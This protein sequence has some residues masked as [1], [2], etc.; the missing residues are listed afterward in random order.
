MIDPDRS[1]DLIDEPWIPVLAGDGTVNEVSLADLLRHA[2]GYVGIVGELPTQGFALL[3]LV[4][5]VLHRTLRRDDGGA[6]PASISEW[7]D[8]WEQW[9]DVAEAA[10]GYLD[11]HRDRFDLFHPDTPFFQVADLHTAKNETSDLDKLIADVPN[12]LPFFTTRTGPGIERITAAEAARWLVH[13]HAFDASGIRSGAVGDSRVKGGKGYPIGPG[14]SGQI[15]GVHLEG[16]T[17]RDTLLLNLI[18]WGDPRTAE[19]TISSGPD[20]VPPWERPQLTATEETVGGRQAR[21]PIDLYTWQTRRVRLDGDR[22]GV[23]GLVLANGDKV[24]PQNQHTREPMSAWRYSEPQ[25]KKHGQVT[26]M[27]LEHR[28]ERQFW[29]G[30]EALLAHTG[31]T[32]LGQPAAR[33]APAL[34]G[35]LGAV[36]RLVGHRGYGLVTVHAVGIVYGSNNSVVDELIDDRLRLPLVL[37]DPTRRELAD[38]AVR[39]LS[40]ADEAAAAAASFRQNLARAAGAGSDESEGPRDQAR[41][42]VYHALDAPF[43][44]WLLSFGGEASLLDAE[45]RWQ[46]EVRAVVQRLGREWLGETGP[47]AWTGRAVRGHRLDAGL[48]DKWFQRK[49]REVLPAA[50]HDREVS[51]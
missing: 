33:L 22:G 23:A 13:V 24:L 17:L 7:A 37:L 47:A 19:L 4:L 18:A 34:M 2:D 46:S 12:G 40:R 10:I 39:A 9:P 6:G 5:A 1:F 50:Y 15:G 30:L 3:R 51:A 38:G 25:T 35:W 36:D 31:A 41:T 48:A 42:A 14:W 32:S 43:R 20:D 44:A 29:R 49:L 11:V 21:G 16:R 27:P 28:V 45:H 8:L 26:Y